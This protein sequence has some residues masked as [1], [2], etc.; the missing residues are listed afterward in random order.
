M[1]QELFEPM[2]MFFSITNSLAMFQTMMNIFF[3]ELIDK[4]VV[5]IYMDNILIFSQ[6]KE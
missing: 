1:N 3:K 2:V 5:S 6:A 4:G